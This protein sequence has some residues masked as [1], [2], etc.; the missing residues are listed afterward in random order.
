MLELCRWLGDS[1]GI[2]V[3]GEERKEGGTI[4][5]RQQKKGKCFNVPR[6]HARADLAGNS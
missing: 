4:V 5:V 1:G 6:S 3:E 2:K